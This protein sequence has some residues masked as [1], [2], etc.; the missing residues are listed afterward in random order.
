MLRY[1]SQVLQLGKSS[2]NHLIIVS[3]TD[4]EDTSLDSYEY[5][6]ATPS[7]S[8]SDSNSPEELAQNVLVA[9][10]MEP[11]PNDPYMQI[12]N[13]Y[14]QVYGGDI[15]IVPTL[16]PTPFIPHFKTQD[17][18]VPEVVSPPR[19]KLCIIPPTPPLGMKWEIVLIKH[20]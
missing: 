19:K 6:P 14:M 12:Y 10:A 4:D 17:C 15:P 1:F 7:H 13:N 3:K 11:S 8:L 2:L 5:A 16:T 9:L 20:L 18:Y